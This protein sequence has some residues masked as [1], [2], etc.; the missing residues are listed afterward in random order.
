MHKRHHKTPSTSTNSTATI[1]NNFLDG[2]SRGRAAI[3]IREIQT[4]KTENPLRQ[5]LELI[6]T[7]K[8]EDFLRTQPLELSS[9]SK[10]NQERLKR[11]IKKNQKAIDEIDVNDTVGEEGTAQIIRSPVVKRGSSCDIIRSFNDEDRP[12]SFNRNKISAR[13]IEIDKQTT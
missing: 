7:F 4:L 10:L 3:S 5:T 8:K 2:L 6:S 13:E 11:K 9:T 1:S 12:R